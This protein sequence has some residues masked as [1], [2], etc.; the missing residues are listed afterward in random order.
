MS[1]ESREATRDNRPRVRVGGRFAGEVAGVELRDGG[2]EVVEVECDECRDQLVGVDL[3]DHQHFG[4]ERVCLRVALFEKGVAEAQTIAPHG[5]RCRRGI[6]DAP[7]GD[8]ANAGDFRCA[9]VALSAEYPPPVFDPDVV[10]KQR[11]EF[12]PPAA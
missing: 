8:R 12:V 1:V 6:N 10:G 3:G 5:E 7:V 2:V 4:D 9:V 11:A